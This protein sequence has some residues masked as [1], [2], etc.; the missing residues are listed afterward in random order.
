MNPQIRSK[1]DS[2]GFLRGDRAGYASILILVLTRSGPSDTHNQLPIHTM[3]E[4]GFLI[5]V[6]P[7][8]ELI[9]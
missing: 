6:P 3:R 1:L 2:H 8:S 5:P 7:A 4:S 9:K